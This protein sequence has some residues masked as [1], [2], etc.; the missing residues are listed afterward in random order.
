MAI[1]NI[2]KSI[3]EMIT[4]M[5]SK[6]LNESLEYSLKP[7]PSSLMIISAKKHQEK[8]SFIRLAIASRSVFLGYESIANAAV[9]SMIKKVITRVKTQWVQIMKLALKRQLFYDL[10]GSLNPPIEKKPDFTPDVAADVFTKFNEVLS[11]IVSDF[12]GDS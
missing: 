12:D 5:A 7:S 10:S 2:A 6:M 8:I 11:T 9:L 3:K 1:V 4:R